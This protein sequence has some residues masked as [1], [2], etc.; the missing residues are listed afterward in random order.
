MKSILQLILVALMAGLSSPVV[1]A[2]SFTFTSLP[3]F[4]RGLNNAGQVVG[5][6][7]G[8]RDHLRA[9]V[10]P[11]LLYHDL[12][13]GQPRY[14]RPWYQQPEPDYGQLHRHRRL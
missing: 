13:A 14:R 5:Y 11:W 6:G 12:C 9:V 10:R 4:A 8:W 7:G 3:L 1:Q 2:E